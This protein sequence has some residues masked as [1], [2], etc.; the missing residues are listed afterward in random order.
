MIVF[1]SQHQSPIWSGQ[2][3]GF[4]NGTGNRLHAQLETDRNT[5]G[6]SSHL[7]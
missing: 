5:E 6:L 4:L 7:I 2:Q 1:C 3:T